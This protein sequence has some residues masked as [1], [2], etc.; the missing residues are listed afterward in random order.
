MAIDA[1]EPR[2]P[3]R[4]RRRLT[5]RPSPDADFGCILFDA[6]DLRV[7]AYSHYSYL[8]DAVGLN[9]H[10]KAFYVCGQEAVTGHQIRRTRTGTWTELKTR[11]GSTGTEV[12]P[13]DQLVE[14]S[15]SLL[16]PAVKLSPHPFGINYVM[17]ETKDQ[18]VVDAR[19]ALLEQV[20][21]S[22][23]ISQVVDWV[24]ERFSVPLESIGLTGSVLMS[25]EPSASDT[26]LVLFVN[27][28]HAQRIEIELDT[29]TASSGWDASEYGVKWRYRLR[30][31]ELGVICLFLAYSDKRDCPIDLHTYVPLSER[32]DFSV[33]VTDATFGGYSPAIY[34]CEG[35]AD[36][37]VVNYLIIL[38]TAA[39]GAFRRGDVVRGS[40]SLAEMSIN[41]AQTTSLVVAFPFK[42]L[43]T[44]H[45][46][47][48]RLQY[49]RGNQFTNPW[50]QQ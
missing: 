28:D 33:T 30:H 2:L 27:P 45:L 4:W 15:L 20:Q 40:A 22:M 25:N 19:E 17:I 41:N 11:V 37:G 5:N 18:S 47:A 44:F 34:E 31:P 21:R 9:A 13:D 6:S 23:M 35:L 16:A 38:G 10:A 3:I 29:I 50:L 43:E 24:T 46:R 1:N 39:R 14:L 49:G 7:A 36:G 12:V 42:Q 8:F 32:T 26:D 48:K